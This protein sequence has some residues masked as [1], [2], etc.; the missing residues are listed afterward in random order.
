[1]YF[2]VKSTQDGRVTLSRS[3]SDGLTAEQLWAEKKH[4]QKETATPGSSL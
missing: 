4:E 1:M 3:E 2:K